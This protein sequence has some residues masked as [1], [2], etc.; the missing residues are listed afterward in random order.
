MALAAEAAEKDS[1]RLTGTIVDNV[2]G[3]RKEELVPP[4]LKHL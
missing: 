4:Y 1:R 3:T 2:I